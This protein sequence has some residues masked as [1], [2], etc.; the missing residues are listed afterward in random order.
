MTSLRTFGAAA[1]LV[2]VA[3]FAPGCGAAPAGSAA[4]STTASPTARAA[5]WTRSEANA[6]LTQALKGF[7]TD[8]DELYRQRNEQH[9]VAVYAVQ[10]GL[11]VPELTSFLSFL[12]AGRW[13]VSVQ[14]AVARLAGA[15]AIY[16]RGLGLCADALDQKRLLAGFRQM[17]T[18]PIAELVTRLRTALGAGAA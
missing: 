11:L 10:C 4:Q 13:P 14:P 7:S 8:L 2:A 1:T 3:L 15:Q 18:A 5:T 12:R 16:N 9:S 17:D 6:A